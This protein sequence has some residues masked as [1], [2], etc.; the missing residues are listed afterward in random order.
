MDGAVVPL[1]VEHAATPAVGIVTGVSGR[2]FVAAALFSAATALS[3]MMWI[4]LAPIAPLVQERFDTSANA[5]NLVSL[6]FL[7]L[8]LPASVMAMWLV[9]A[10]GVRVTLLVGI[11]LD[12]AGCWLKWA[13]ALMSNPAAGFALVL[14]GQALGALGQPAILNVPARVAADW[15]PSSERDLAT[16]VLTMANVVGQMVAS[17]A[18]PR[19]VTQSDG[20]Q[21]P[22]VLLYTGAIPNTVLVVLTAVLYSERPPQPPSASVAAQWAER[23]A[24]ASNPGSAASATLR[25]LTTM[26]GD[27]KRLMT[28]R[29][30]VFLC[31]SFS[32]ATGM[33]WTLLTVQVWREEVG[34][35]REGLAGFVPPAGLQRAGTS[36]DT[37]RHRP[38]RRGQFWCRVAGRWCCHQSVG[39]ATAGADAEIRA[40]ATAVCVG[41]RSGGRVCAGRQRP[42]QLRVDH[43]RMVRPAMACM[44]VLIPQET[45]RHRF[46]HTRGDGSA[47][48]CLVRLCNPSSPL[49]WNMQQK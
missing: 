37:V 17:L 23:D 34:G 6:L 41:L 44:P 49:R 5:V 33:S 38:G 36:S 8:Y 25:T 47:G 19:M 2:R 21:L 13:G 12:A 40:A 9:D 24:I 10:Y 16:V 14:A 27:T 7:I 48:P 30:F 22:A 35:G 43:R 32:A 31:A 4:V 46:P 20:S 26:W 39:G 1:L 28:N 29:A 3:A 42:W 15:F 45:L 11:G 18:A